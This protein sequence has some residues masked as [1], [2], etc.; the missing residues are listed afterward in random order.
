M[1]EEIIELIKA[2]DKEKNKRELSMI[3]YFLK[4][5]LS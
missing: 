2:L 3:Y 1:K 5:L 4:G